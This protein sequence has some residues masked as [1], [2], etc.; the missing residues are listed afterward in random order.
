MKKKCC[1]K[2]GARGVALFF[3]ALFLTMF[4]GAGGVL[5][6]HSE[7]FGVAPLV[8]AAEPARLT[9]PKYEVL[10]C[11]TDHN[12]SYVLTLDFETKSHRVRRL[13]FDNSIYKKSGLSGMN[14]EA[15]KLG[16]N[17]HAALAVTETQLA[18]LIDY[19]GGVHCTVDETLSKI[20]DGVSV[21][22]Q[23]LCGVAAI[24]LFSSERQYEPLCLQLVEEVFL[25][26]CGILDNRRCFFKLLELS[27]ND[28]SYAGYLPLQG[29]FK[30]IKEGA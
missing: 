7:W 5:L 4:F 8:P 23:E 24:K 26:W 2:W 15:Q 1:K 11:E 29:E 30:A 6:W 14:K 16:T 22:E 3:T 28:L 13:Y 27:D 10:F 17:F 25:K 9:E 12:V 20:L 18:A 21:G 19:S